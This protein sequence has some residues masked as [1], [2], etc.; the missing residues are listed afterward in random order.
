MGVYVSF[1]PLLALL[2][3]RSLLLLALLLALITGAGR[4]LLS[5]VVLSS[6]PKSTATTAFDVN[7]DWLIS[8]VTYI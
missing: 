1:L 4:S 6:L 3:G 8:Y 7:F 5:A 2:M